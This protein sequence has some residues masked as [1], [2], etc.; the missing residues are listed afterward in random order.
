M[1]TVYI[2]DSNYQQFINPVIDGE[3]YSCSYF[4]MHRPRVGLASTKTF[5]D[6]GVPLIPESEWKDRIKERI[7]NKTTTR[8]FVKALDI[9]HLDQNGT[10]Y[11]WVNGVTHAIEL[12]RGRELGRYVSLSPASAGARIKNFRNV[13][14]WGDEALDWIREHGINETKDWPANAIDRRYLTEENI[15][16][17]K[18]N[19]SVEFYYLSTGQQGWRE[20]VSC[21]LHGLWAA[22]GYNWWSHLVMGADLNMNLD[23]DIRNSWKNWGENGFGYLQGSRKYP[24]GSVVP[25][26]STAA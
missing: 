22:V 21:I 16:K 1:S 6:L 18:L 26:I 7:D 9:P 2:N 14:G 5:G 24:D 8:H 25:V 23:L 10:N 11:C 12:C 3:R 4:G 15:D 19:C 17:A 13:G 20:T